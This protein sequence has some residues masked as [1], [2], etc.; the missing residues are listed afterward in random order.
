MALHSRIL[1]PKEVRTVARLLGKANNSVDTK[2]RIVI[3]AAMREE[4]GEVFFITIGAENCLTIYPENKWDQMSEDFEELAYTE[5]RELSMLFAN[6]AKCEPDSQG[7]FLIPAALREYAGLKK[8]ATI[9][10][11]NSFA[12]IW[13]ESA[14]TEREARML[15]KGNLA[16]AMDALAKARRARKG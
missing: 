1:R 6:A 10:G 2:G 13:D 8:N 16:A 7:R 4:L 15:S 14:W 5:A 11:M 12:E 3:P 9:V